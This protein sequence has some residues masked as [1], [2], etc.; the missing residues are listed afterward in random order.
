[1]IEC[2]GFDKTGAWGFF[3]VWLFGFVGF[4]SERSRMLIE[5]NTEDNTDFLWKSPSI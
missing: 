1:M 2:I 5:F 4:F 3:S